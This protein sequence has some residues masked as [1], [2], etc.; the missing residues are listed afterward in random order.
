MDTDRTHRPLRAGIQIAS[1]RPSTGQAI[2]SLGR[3][4][5]TGL[6]IHG[7]DA[8]EKRV[9]VT[10]LHVMASLDVVNKQKRL[11]NPQMDE[12]M[13]QTASTFVASTHRVGSPLAAPVQFSKT[14]KNL[15]DAAYVDL[16]P[17][18]EANFTLH[19]HP[20]AN[21]KNIHANRRVIRDTVAPAVDEEYI[22][23]GGF[24][25]EHKVKAIAPADGTML[26]YP[27][28]NLYAVTLPAGC[29]EGD[30]G[31]PVLKE[32]AP[33]QYKMV[34][35]YI[36]SDENSPLGVIVLASNVEALLGIKFGSRDP[37]A[38]A[39]GPW[40]V[41]TGGSGQLFGRNSKD[42]DKGALTYRWGQFYEGYRPSPFAYRP[43]GLSSL[44]AVNPTFTAPSVPTKATFRLQVTDDSG[45]TAEDFVTVLVQGRV[46]GQNAARPTANAG[47]RQT[48]YAE[49]PVTLGKADSQTG[50][51]REWEQLFPD[52]LTAKSP[53]E[54]S[55][56]SATAAQPTFTAPSVS[57]EQ[58]KKLYFRLTAASTNGAGAADVATIRVKSNIEQ[59]GEL[60]K[61]ASPM[62]KN[63]WVSE[64][65]SAKRRGRYARYYAFTLKERSKMTIILASS[66]DCYLNLLRGTGTSGDILAYNDDYGLGISGHSKL[67]QTLDA[68]SYTI[69]ATTAL[70]GEI[71]TFNL[72]VAVFSDD[73]AL[74][75]L[76]GRRVPRRCPRRLMQTPPSTPPRWSTPSPASR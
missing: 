2:I 9:L 36:G 21:N 72:S 43:V 13:Y 23:F 20:L 6:A 58:E 42:P 64:I 38:V 65:K 17:G 35:M 14:R 71:G 34:G 45:A 62:V 53:D 50:V 40:M 73:A 3:G 76:E 19:T 47:G 54:V 1:G 59:L 22:M 28:D 57:P 25:G 68:G 5:L 32:V 49:N 15:I 44:T 61:G 69:E 74:K 31:A 70:A 16:L 7:K 60:A 55:L 39:E 51:A 46:P 52:K 33:N 29:G 26:G 11:R 56:S 10:C 67:E 24:C 48:V 27:F 63:N 30:S 41:A 75:S 37:I 66:T 18:I 8:A 12:E 4:T